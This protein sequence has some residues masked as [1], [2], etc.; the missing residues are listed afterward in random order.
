MKHEW[1]IIYSPYFHIHIVVV[2]SYIQCVLYHRYS[3]C[4]HTDTVMDGVRSDIVVVLSKHSVFDVRYSG[5][6][7]TNI[8]GMMLQ[9]QWL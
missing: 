7:F 5:Y 6:E 2:I 3:G 9:I 4:D 1:N 8:V